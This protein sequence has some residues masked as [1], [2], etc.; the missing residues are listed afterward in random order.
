[1]SPA[2]PRKGIEVIVLSNFERRQHCTARHTVPN[3]GRWVR[4]EREALGVIIC[5]NG[6]RQHK[7][8]CLLC[9]TTGSPIPTRQLDA[10]GLT[11]A[12]I[13][14]QHTNAAG[15]YPPC[16]YRDCP[17]TPTELHHFSPRNTFGDDA[18]NWPVLPL[19]REHHVHW[20]QRMDGYRWHRKGIAA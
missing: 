15:D 18:D 9:G 5:A 20:H 19:C 8:R 2:R 12:D 7:M 11:P 17:V 3:Q 16:S 10:W 14:W 1:M 6:T 13:T 4:G